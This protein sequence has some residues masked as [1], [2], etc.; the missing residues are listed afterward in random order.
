[1]SVDYFGTKIIDIVVVVLSNKA[2]DFSHIHQFHAVNN[3]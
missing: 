3:S 2:L 1:M